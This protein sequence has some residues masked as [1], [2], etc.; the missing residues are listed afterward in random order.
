MMIE[1]GQLP[2]LPVRLPA[3]PALVVRH[4]EVIIAGTGAAGMAAALRL[5]ESGRQVT[6]IS[7]GRLPDGSTAWAQGGLAAVTDSSDSTADHFRDTL[8][9]GAGLCDSAAVSALVSQAPAAIDRLLGNGAVFDR[10]TAERLVLGLEGGH[11]HRRVVHAGGDAT[12]AEIARCLAARLHDLR[13]TTGRLTILENTAAIDAIVSAD[14]SVTGLTVLDDDGC[15]VDLPAPAVVLATGGI[16]QAWESTTNPPTATGDGIGIGLRAGAVI[17]DA[18]FV[19]FHPTML[20]VPSQHRIRGDR[21]VLISEAVRGE[22]ARIVDG[23]GSL[24]MSGRH[25]RGDLAPR[26]VVAAT[27]HARLLETGADQLY[28]DG[29]RLG[30]WAWRDHFP[31]ILDMC[32]RR[33]VDP[34]SEPVPVRPGEHYACGGVLATM[35]GV[36]TV[37]GLYAIGE[38]A[39]T[40]VHGANRLASNSLTEALITG[41]RLGRLLSADPEPRR[42]RD[43][44]A[45]IREAEPVRLPEFMTSGLTTS[46]EPTQ[47]RNVTGPAVT[48]EQ[49]D[50]PSGKQAPADH[51]PEAKDRPVSWAIPA[52]AREPAV[53]A[54]S[55]G[56]GVLRDETGLSVLLKSLDDCPSH[57]RVVTRADLEATNI[58]SLGVVLAASALAR[59]ESRGCHRRADY[60]N[61]EPGWQRHT[62]AKLGT[63]GDLVI[64]S[65]EASAEAQT[66]TDRTPGT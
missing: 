62:L 55:R 32:R 1:N 46:P 25:P 42:N 37:P 13:T 40:G 10:D 17:R 36:T 14:G 26:D 47:W 39:S 38:T 51:L 45:L 9:A 60:P 50:H 24:V 19:Q 28:L 59:T 66:S 21:G 64:H 56:A 15:R 6:L 29:T 33:G 22:G 43:G 65:P 11:S 44:A 30:A 41:N 18:E 61:T 27:M 35:D 48:D 31:T 12:G 16:G 5:V 3:G 52:A 49:P 57:D 7:K 2:A 58:Y 8:T 20:V 54:T 34:I 4:T 23:D 53:A 63:D